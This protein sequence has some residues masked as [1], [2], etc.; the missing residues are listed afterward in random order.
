MSGVYSGETGKERE[1]ENH[2]RSLF[3]KVKQEAGV[4]EYIL[5]SAK[6]TPGKFFFY[7]KYKDR[8]VLECHMNTAYL[9]E[10]FGKFEELVSGEPQV[11]LYEIVD[12]IAD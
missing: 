4:E 1:L 8:Q 7:E 2:L 10:A 11:E 5:H 12:S 3:P 9:K 6:S